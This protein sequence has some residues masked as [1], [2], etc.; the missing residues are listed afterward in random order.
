MLKRSPAVALLVGLASFAFASLLHA[1]D[2]RWVHR[3]PYDFGARTLAIAV[4]PANPE[5]VFAGSASSGLW[6]REPG[7]EWQRVDTSPHRVLGVAAIAIHPRDPNVIFAGT[8]EV[9]RYRQADLGLDDHT[10]RGNYGIGILVSRDRGKSWQSS[11][12]WQPSD[13]TGV[14]DLAIVPDGDSAPGFTVWAATTEGVYRLRTRLGA[15]ADADRWEQSL[16]VIMVT[17][18]SPNPARPGELLVACGSAASAGHGL[19]LTE[20]GGESWQKLLDGVPAKFE[21]KAV[22]GRSPSELS[23]V[24]ASIGNQLFFAYGNAQYGSGQG[25]FAC[26]YQSLKVDPVNWLLRSA[27]G[28]RSWTTQTTQ[29]YASSQ[30]WY[31]HAVA[32]SPSDPDRLWIVGT[33]LQRSF[34][35]GKS[36]GGSGAGLWTIV[37]DEKGLY[38]MADSHRIVVA[39]GVAGASERL[40]FA[41]DQGV[42][43]SL[44]GGRSIQAW[45]EGYDVVQLYRAASSA[46]ASG[47]VAATAQDQGP[48]F[49]LYQPPGT[50]GGDGWSWVAGYGHEAGAIA[51][52]AKEDLL[53]VG[54]HFNAR[55]GRYRLGVASDEQYDAPDND[56]GGSLF[57]PDVDPFHSSD[58][59][60]DTTGWYGPVEVSA[61]GDVLYAARNA[62][63]RSTR[64]SLTDEDPTHSATQKAA[65]RTLALAWEPTGFG[66]DRNPI[67]ALAVSPSSSSKVVAVTDPR[68]EPMHVYASP[69]GGFTWR[70]LTGDALPRDRQPRAIV[71]D[72]AGKR[73]FLVFG[74]FGPGH[75]WTAPLDDGA[76]SGSGAA[77]AWRALDGD[78]TKGALPDVPHADLAVDSATGDLYVANQWGVYRS[79]DGGASWQPWSE[80]LYPAVESMQLLLYAKE[81]LLRLVAHGDGLWERALPAAR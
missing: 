53:Y 71:L 34:D 17:S 15:A 58:N 1:A 29:S 50:K 72:E 2:D 44:D 8:G 18:L 7:A 51:Y 59:C 27:D 65:V 36:F 69:D 43:R 81:R 57:I 76:W 62:L 39:P 23:V 20:D 19:Y 13:R 24:Y 4:D 40:Y 11:L 73:L 56:N 74:D 28:G 54:Q 68:Y 42:Y 31:S 70:D 45:N 48:G 41:S 64:T 66:K 77:P 12:A 49:Y 30:G 32:V 67:A 78:A 9:Y 35:G 61:A 46:A 16:P 55:L 38:Y 5:R 63:Y 47:F 37:N 6:K 3:G 10:T 22:L 75:V 80:G 79:R 14:Q 25:A 60:L 33:Q 21:G 52:S 26:Q